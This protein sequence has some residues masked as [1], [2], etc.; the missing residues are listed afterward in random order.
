MFL[1]CSSLSLQASH[2]H[3][4]STELSLIASEEQLLFTISKFSCLVSNEWMAPVW[5]YNVKF[6]MK[7]CQGRTV[8]FTPIHSIVKK[9]RPKAGSDIRVAFFQVKIEVKYPF[10]QCSKGRKTKKKLAWQTVQYSFLLCC[11]SCYAIAQ[12]PFHK[13]QTILTLQKN[14]RLLIKKKSKKQKNP[15][16]PQK[17]KKEPQTS[18]KLK[19]ARKN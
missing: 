6:F 10:W 19:Q 14:M 11:L 3:L 13:L 5:Q 12:Q 2:R 16:T 17:T 7:R 15:K 18:N 8:F 1:S 9:K 4:S